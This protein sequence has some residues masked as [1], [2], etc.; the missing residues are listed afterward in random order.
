MGFQ[1]ER[2]CC[3]I[4]S[5]GPVAAHSNEYKIVKQGQC[6]A[7]PVCLWSRRPQRKIPERVE[8]YGASVKELSGNCITEA[9]PLNYLGKVQIVHSTL[10]PYDLVNGYDHISQLFLGGFGVQIRCHGR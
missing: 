7:V 2:T 9:Y 10:L 1:G 4:A 6:L 8:H 3:P 5:S